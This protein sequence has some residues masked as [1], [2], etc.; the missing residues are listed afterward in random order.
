MWVTTSFFGCFPIKFSDRDFEI[1]TDYTWPPL[2][3]SHESRLVGGWCRISGI[4]ESGPLVRHGSGIQGECRKSCERDPGSD[5]GH[6]GVYR[7]TKGDFS[8]EG[9]RGIGGDPAANHWAT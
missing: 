5:R 1:V 3:R 7:S 2:W 4:G 6:Q 8:T 9:T